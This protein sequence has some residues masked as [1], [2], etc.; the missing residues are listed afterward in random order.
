VRKAI[1]RLRRILQPADS[2]VPFVKVADTLRARAGLF[3]ELRSALRLRPTSGDVEASPRLSTE[4]AAAELRDIEAAV[5]AL[6]TSLA[7]RRP[8]RG[9][10]QDRRQAIDIVLTHL[11]RHG[12]TLFG[13]VVRLPDGAGEITR[14]VDRTNNSLEGL[15]DTMKHGERRRSGRKILTQDFEQLP[16]AAALA[17]NLHSS[18]YVA[19]VCGSLD[20]LPRAFAQLD[21]ADR[22]R[23]CIVSRTAARADD[24]TDC[25]V[26]SAS[27]P[28]A[29][30][31]LVRTDEMSRRIH[32]AARSRPP[33]P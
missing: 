9:P 26:V 14:L 31:R 1:E 22:R 33:R 18:D 20:Q 11:D 24:A 19:T 27:L 30:R 2:Q 4:Q 21:A 23:S 5:G 28:T 32:A 10:A 6:P 16:P 29:D 7:R 25:D 12:K 13:H 8:E 15:W 17:T 3:T